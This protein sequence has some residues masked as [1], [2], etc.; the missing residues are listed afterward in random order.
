VRKIV[1]ASFR[2]PGG[3]A[4]LAPE[5]VKH[6]PKH[7]RKFIDLFCGRGN[8][9]FRA[10]AEGLD[11][12]E[13]V[14]NDPL[15]AP[16]LHAIR[17]VGDKVA[18]PQRSREEFDRQKAL[19]ENGDQR[20][21]LLAPHLCFNGG[22]YSSGGSTTEGGRRTPQSYEANLRLAHTAMKLANPRI[23]QLDWLDCVE[24]EN[25]GAGDFVLLDVPYMDCE[26]G[27]YKPDSVIPAELVRWLKDAPCGW[28]LCEYRQPFY[29]ANLGKP[30]YT[31]EVQN[32][33]TNF[34]KAPQQRRFE[35]L[36]TNIGKTALSANVP[37]RCTA[38]VPKNYQALSTDELL[39][40]IKDAAA[41]IVASQIN[42]S[43][44]MRKRLL[45][46]LIVLKKRLKR[47]KPGFY[48]TLEKMGL[49]PS[50]VRS[51]FYRRRAADE[52][53]QML[54]RAPEAPSAPKQV[55]WETADANE[56]LLRHCD[57]M[58]A[59]VL[60]EKTDWAKR[61]AAEYANARKM[62]TEV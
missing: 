25:P 3:K 48:K 4:L 9:F 2:W 53:I 54:E 1:A 39:K 7:G 41:S 36:W 22:T 57:K 12:K 27:P 10:A 30:L 15:T 28:I 32:R 23:T 47:K 19:A 37:D 59:A 5:I 26:V 6:I 35:C 61:L 46:A 45:P 14:L 11:Y 34:A 13:W 60:R 16:F 20:A 18:L 52:V 49:N 31:R 62:M 29:L 24:A 58:A 50:T 40:E 8:V 56:E 42:T 44:E 33:A 43:A 21:L 55:Q 51:W 17:D 38:T